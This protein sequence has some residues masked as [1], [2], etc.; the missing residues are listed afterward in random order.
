MMEQMT[1]KDHE[2]A[3]SHDFRRLCTLCMKGYDQ[4][5]YKCARL[6]EDRTVPYSY[7][8][9]LSATLVSEAELKNRLCVH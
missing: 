4:K 9:A 7:L 1:H 6:P 5:A 2:T 3:R 8:S